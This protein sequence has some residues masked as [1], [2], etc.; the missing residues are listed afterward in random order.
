MKQYHD[1]LHHILDHGVHKSDRTGTGTL[2][3]FGYQ[4]RFNL[5]DGFPLV[6]TKK[7]HFK[8]I[9]GELLWF[10]SGSTNATELRENYGVTIWDEWARDDGQLGPVYGYQWRS[11]PARCGAEPI[12]Q[13][14]ALIDGIRKDPDSRR[15]IV[16]A[17]NV[18]DLPDMALPPCHCLFQFY[19][20]DGKLSCQLLPAQRG[21]VPWSAVQHRQLCLADK[22]DRAANW[23]AGGRVYLDRR[24][25]PPLRQPPCPSARAAGPRTH[26]VAAASAGQPRQH[27]RLQARAYQP[28]RLRLTPG[29]SGAGRGLGLSLVLRH[30]I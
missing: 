3:V 10:L 22:H 9:V 19:V 2:S 13:I 23:P 28:D 20:A 16:S 18:A 24:R 7:V 12:D 4:M 25:L 17:W 5:A 1:L 14:R 26:S 29:H 30:Q 8:S 27:Q 15:H 11:W 21:R 6:T